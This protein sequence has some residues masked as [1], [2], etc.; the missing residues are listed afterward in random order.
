MGLKTLHKNIEKRNTIPIIGA[1]HVKHGIATGT[2][3]DMWYSTPTVERMKMG[4][5]HRDGFKDGIHLIDKD[6][7]IADFPMFSEGLI[8]GTPL[9]K[10]TL[11]REQMKIL[12]WVSKAMSTEE[13][14]Y[15]LNGIY[16]DRD[17]FIATDGHRLHQAF[18]PANWDKRRKDEGG[19]I[20]P[21][22]VIKLFI[23]G[24]KET[25]AG[26]AEIQF[27]KSGAVIT[28]GKTVIKTKTVD[29]TFPD[30]KRV[31]PK[32]YKTKKCKFSAKEIARHKKTVMA[33]MKACNG[34][35]NAP[36]KF[37]E[38]EKI[39]RYGER[40]HES[41]FD[42]VTKLPYTVGFNYKYLCD[43][44]EGEVYFTDS[45]SPHVVKGTDENTGIDLMGILMPLRV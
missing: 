24:M 36:V 4:M 30:Y 6:L 14:R 3:I 15:Y 43:M 20:L 29:G 28:F 10:I 8:K 13:T 44:N 7:P 11:D 39:V 41:T 34:S 21:R 25:K 1:V 12:E 9:A 5:Y 19:V 33:T 26:S 40:E 22:K 18:Y 37:I 45:S 16:F 31:V 17:G 2:D 23:D 27:W 42:V 38:N 32:I 35:A